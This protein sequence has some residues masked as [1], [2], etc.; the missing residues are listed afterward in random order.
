MNYYVASFCTFKTVVEIFVRISILSAYT[1]FEA[2][3]YTGTPNVLHCS[4]EVCVVVHGSLVA[5][6]KN[7]RLSVFLLFTFYLEVN[8]V[9]INILLI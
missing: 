9:L 2:L 7:K 1:L 4:V 6:G 3:K 5:T 8:V